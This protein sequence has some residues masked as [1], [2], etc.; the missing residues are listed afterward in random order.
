MRLQFK[1]QILL[2]PV[3]PDE[4]VFDPLAPPLFEQFCRVGAERVEAG[5]ELRRS[6]VP[7]EEIPQFFRAPAFLPAFA[8]P[9]GM[10]IAKARLGGFEFLEQSFRFVALAGEAAQYGVDETGLRAIAQLAGQRDG[11]V[12][13]R[14]VGDAVEP[15][16]LIEAEAQQRLQRGFL[17]AARSFAGNQPVE[18]SL[19]ADDAIGQFLTEGAVAGRQR[20]QLGLEEVFDIVRAPVALEQEA[21]GNFSWFL[22][23][24]GLIM[25]PV[26]LRAS[27][28]TCYERRVRKTAGRRQDRPPARGAIVAT[29]AE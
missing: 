12:H 20:G 23:A 27:F 14:M 18:C 26:S 13:H 15:E 21:S 4:I 1:D 25:T 19:P 28:L 8:K 6:V 24:H 7:V 29:G 3:P 11:F 10:G 17:R 16:Y 5:E 22:N 9:V 2:K